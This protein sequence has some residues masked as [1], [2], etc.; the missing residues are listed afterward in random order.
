MAASQI[1]YRQAVAEDRHRLG[2]SPCP[3]RYDRSCGF[4]RDLVLA[5]KEFVHFTHPCALIRAAVRHFA[6]SGGGSSLSRRAVHLAD[7]FE[8]GAIVQSQLCLIERPGRTCAPLPAAGACLVPPPRPPTPANSRRGGHKSQQQPATAF[9]APASGRQP[10]RWGFA[11]ARFYHFLKRHPK[12]PNFLFD[13]D[14]RNAVLDWNR[15]QW[16]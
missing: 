7:H 5:G 1:P 11:S 15:S 6:R 13:I 9:P 2:K 3:N 14:N 16:W 8:P 10:H 12:H 4:P